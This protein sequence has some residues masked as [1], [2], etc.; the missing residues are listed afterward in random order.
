MCV[1]RDLF[2]KCVSIHIVDQPHHCAGE[3][4]FHCD[5]RRKSLCHRVFCKDIR[6]YK[7][8]RIHL[9]VMCVLSCSTVGVFENIN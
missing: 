3:R 5:V 9:N 2:I 1:I 4:S 8:V 7:V 6:T